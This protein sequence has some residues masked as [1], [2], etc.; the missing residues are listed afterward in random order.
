MVGVDAHVPALVDVSLR[1]KKGEF[2]F[3]TGSSGAGKSTLLNLMFGSEI[4]SEGQIIIDGR[5]YKKIPQKE[6]P[7]LRQKIGFI[8]QDFKLIKNRSVFENVALALKVKGVRPA[9]VRKRVQRALSYVRL[10]HRANFN[11]L[12]LSGGEQ[13]RVAVA[14]ALVK[15]PT[16]LLADEPTGNLDPD[17]AIEMMKLFNDVNSKGTTV[18]VATHDHAMIERF[19]KKTLTLHKGRV[20]L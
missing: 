12:T 2:I 16:I 10:Q 13:Q 5:N 6:V 20:V 7:E 19:N 8:F 15:E 4:Q 18:V 9:E 14:R 17:L 3:V 1:I 11:P